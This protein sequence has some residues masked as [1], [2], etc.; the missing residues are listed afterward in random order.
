MGV[1]LV[2]LWIAADRPMSEVELAGFEG[3]HSDRENRSL[4][5]NKM[6]FRMIA[7]SLGIRVGS[8]G[9]RRMLRY[10]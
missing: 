7:Y 4:S 2:R 10:R 5:A 9:G 8:A 3:F 6:E 1:D